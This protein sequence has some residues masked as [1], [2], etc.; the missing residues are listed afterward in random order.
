M[1][2]FKP[3]ILVPLYLYPES[4]AWKPLYKQISAHPR[5]N[6]TVIVNPNSGP[7]VSLGVMPNADWITAISSLNAHP[8]V[9]TIGYVHT[10][11]ATRNISQVCEEI[12]TYS[13]WSRYKKADIH[14]D[15][16][17]FDESPTEPDQ[18]LIDYIANVSSHARKKLT[19]P[20]AQITLNPGVP[21]TSKYY[22]H[23]DHIVAFEDP[24]SHYISGQDAAPLNKIPSANRRK[25]TFII[26]DFNGTAAKQSQLLHS[27]FA[28]NVEGIYISTTDQYDKYSTM[29][30]QLVSQIAIQQQAFA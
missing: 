27:I 23:A 6:F 30:P 21:V 7:G 15:G 14:L 19:K 13:A 8:N 16:I 29:W 2:K 24:Y 11:H 22:N 25:S 20:A 26:N 10:E 9:Q 12:D 28:N 5:V 4:G 3:Y 18:V 17:F 1:V